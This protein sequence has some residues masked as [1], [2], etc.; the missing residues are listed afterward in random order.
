MYDQY[1]NRFINIQFPLRKIDELDDDQDGKDDEQTEQ[2]NNFG[3]NF[4]LRA[5]INQ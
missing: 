4:L 1:I 2:L 3:K 5:K